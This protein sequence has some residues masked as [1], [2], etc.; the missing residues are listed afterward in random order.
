MGVR[1]LLGITLIFTAQYV[2]GQIAEPIKSYKDPYYC[3]YSKV[4]NLQAGTYLSV[5]TGP[6]MQF[7]KI[8]RLKNESVVY[9]CDE[10]SEWDQIF[11]SAPDRPCVADSPVGLLSTKKETCKSGWVKHK[12]VNYISG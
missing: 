1:I 2:Y 9:V 12:W 5:R 4:Y 6:G 10:K 3:N 7:P 11:Y 8:D